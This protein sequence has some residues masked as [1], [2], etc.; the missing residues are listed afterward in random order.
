[1]GRWRRQILIQSLRFR[2]WP[3]SQPQFQKFNHADL[4]RLGESEDVTY[5][6]IVV[7]LFDHFIVYPEP[8]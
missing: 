2:G 4:V 3:S 5:T 1:M 7:R 6:E 8:A